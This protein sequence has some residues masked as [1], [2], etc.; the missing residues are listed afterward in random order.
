MCGIVGL[1]QSYPIDLR[2]VTGMADLLRHRGPDD[3]GFVVFPARGPACLAGDDT[4]SFA[5]VDALAYRPVAHH[6]EWASE[7][8]PT[9]LAMGHRRLSI[10]DLSPLGHQPMSYLD[11]YWIVYNGE[12]FNYVELREE[13]RQAGYHFRSG[14]DTEVLLAGYDKW[15]IGLLDRCNGMWSMAI[16]DRKAKSLFLARDRFGIKPLYYYVGAEGNSLAFA[17]EIKAFSALPNWR[18]EVA[19]QPAFD[20]LAWG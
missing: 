5:G 3:E 9:F 1:V 11:R 4:P 17:S 18:R 15:G 14:S 8:P 19:P 16:Y 10:V 13:L 20:F 2:Q 7:A 6:K 12:V